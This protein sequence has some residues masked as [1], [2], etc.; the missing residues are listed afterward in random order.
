MNENSFSES[1]KAERV[2][3]GYKAVNLMKKHVAHTD[4]CSSG[5]GGFGG[6]SRTSYRYAEFSSAEQAVV[7]TKL[8]NCF[9]P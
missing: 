2:T 5:L 1:Y 4:C 6:L 9:S 3:A 7:G 8:K